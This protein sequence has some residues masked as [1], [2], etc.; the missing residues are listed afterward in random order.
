LEEVRRGLFIMKS[1]RAHDKSLMIHFRDTD[2]SL[3]ESYH[4]RMIGRNKCNFN[5]DK[6]FSVYNDVTNMH[7]RMTRRHG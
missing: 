4:I 1:W 5:L 2:A 7:D 3:C 6:V